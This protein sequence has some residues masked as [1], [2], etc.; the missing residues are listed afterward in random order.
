LSIFSITEGIFSTIAD[1]STNA[2][3]S[4]KE[5]RMVFAC[6][7]LDALFLAEERMRFNADLWFAIFLFVNFLQSRKLL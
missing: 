4:L 5:L 6:K 2:R 3:K 7:R 1:F